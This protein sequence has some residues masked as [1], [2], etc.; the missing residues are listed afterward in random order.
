MRLLFSPTVSRL[1][2]CSLAACLL[3]LPNALLPLDPFIGKGIGLL[4]AIALLWLTEALHVTITALLV[5]ILASLLGV[6]SLPD[7]LLHFAN[8]VLFLFMGGFALAAALHAQQLDRYLAESVILLSGGKL[9]RAVWLLFAVTAFMSMWISNTATVAIMLPLALGLLASMEEK[10]A[11]TATFILLGVAYSAN[12]GGMGSLVGSPPNAIAAAYSGMD[13]MG[14]LRWG[15]PVMLLLLPL[16]WLILYLL[17]RPALH[18]PIQGRTHEWHWS[19]SRC[20]TLLLFALIVMLWLFS[21]PLGKW[22]GN[23]AQFDSLVALV[24]MVLVGGSGLASWKQIETQTE[25]GVLLLFGGGLCLSAAL[26]QS[27]ASLFLARELLA[28]LDGVSSWWIVLAIATFVV[29]LTELASN[30][31]T[32]ALMVPLFGS[33]AGLLG[34]DPQMMAVLVA[35]AASCAFMLPVATPPNAMVFATGRVPQRQMIRVGLV[36]NL[37]C[38]LLLATLVYWPRLFD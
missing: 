35:L 30:T 36:L 29:F 8:P 31:A 16:S 17:L 11:N 15:L 28:M 13:F 34:V 14:W 6:L 2:L 33:M 5:P 37:C 27:G 25:W 20:A 32:A 23:F 10:S 12:L 1:V 26:Q 38:S 22:L 19:L 21:M 3:F 24:A 4:S 18:Q 7:A 9:S